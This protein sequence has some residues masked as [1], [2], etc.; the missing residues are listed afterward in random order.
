MGQG[1]ARAF[2]KAAGGGG[3]DTTP[4]TLDVNNG[5]TPSNGAL[6]VRR[7]TNI[8]ATFSEP[9]DLDSLQADGVFTLKNTRT[10]AMVQTTVITLSSDGKTATLNP[11]GPTTQKLARRTTYVVRI[12]G[13]TGGAAD[14]VGNVLAQDAVWSFK[15]GRK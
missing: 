11:F 6:R 8:S 12:K 15:T 13:G 7:N 2:E 3:G 10:G 1:C 5:V 4:P 9:M 14:E